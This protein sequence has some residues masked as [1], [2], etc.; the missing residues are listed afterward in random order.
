MNIKELKDFVFDFGRV[1]LAEMKLYLQIDRQTLN[2]M[3][4]S[5]V[6]QGIVKKSYTA[7]ECQT[8]QKCNREEIEFYEWAGSV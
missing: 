8:C 1:S 4:D 5:L 2:P 7:K 3:L 6:Q